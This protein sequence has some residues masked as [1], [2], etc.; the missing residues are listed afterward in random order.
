LVCVHCLVEIIKLK[1]FYSK[2]L[3]RQTHKNEKI[4]HLKENE[5]RYKE[6][7]I[8]TRQAKKENNPPELRTNSKMSVPK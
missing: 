4:I 5:K 7:K 2:I 3:Q 8:E 6:K 1:R